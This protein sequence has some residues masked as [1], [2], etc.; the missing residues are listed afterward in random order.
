MFAIERLYQM[1]V[2]HFIATS[3]GVG[4]N[5]KWPLATRAALCTSN[6]EAVN[7]DKFNCRF[8]AGNGALRMRKAV[9]CLYRINYTGGTHYQPRWLWHREM[10]GERRQIR[11][12]HSDEMTWV[13]NGAGGVLTLNRDERGVINPCSGHGSG[14]YRID[15][16]TKTGA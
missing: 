12:K 10:I 3:R 2:P 5:C 15:L 8:L 16:A 9:L 6:G 14:S 1:H 13:R 7:G 11:D 4:R